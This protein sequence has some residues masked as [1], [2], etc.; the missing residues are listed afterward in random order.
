[1][2]RIVQEVRGLYAGK[3]SVYTDIP[4]GSAADS[5][6]NDVLVQIGF[7]D[8]TTK[9][10]FGGVYYVTRSGQD[11]DIYRTFTVNISNT[12]TT[13]CYYLANY[14]WEGVTLD[15]DGKPNSKCTSGTVTIE[16]E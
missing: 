7:R 10:P 6:A 2:T 12:G 11:G 13:D 9:H 8:T 3:K 16:F 14:G 5:T 4:A 1:M 15:D